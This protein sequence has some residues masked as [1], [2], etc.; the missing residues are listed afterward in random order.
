MSITYEASIACERC[1]ALFGS[2]VTSD[3]A[4][5]ARTHAMFRAVK[6]GW[7]ITFPKEAVGQ[8]QILCPA[9][10]AAPVQSEEKP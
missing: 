8:W 4:L 5:K 3:S 1:R 7:S 10:A 9:C 2:G 6:A